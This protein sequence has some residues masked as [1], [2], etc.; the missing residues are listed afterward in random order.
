MEPDDSGVAEIPNN[1]PDRIF[2]LEVVNMPEDIG[3]MYFMAMEGHPGFSHSILR[4]QMYPLKETA[5]KQLEWAIENHCI[6]Y[7][8]MQLKTSKTQLK[9]KELKFYTV[10]PDTQQI[11]TPGITSGYVN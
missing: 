7:L 4:A 6:E 10:D 8:P 5:A 9:V 2:V 3:P 11:V 1:D